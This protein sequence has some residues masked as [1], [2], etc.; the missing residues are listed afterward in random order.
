MFKT[1]TRL[2]AAGLMAATLAAPALAQ[3][4]LVPAQ[5]SIHFVSKQMGVPVEGHFG[6]FD[7]QIA[8]D[9]AK[10]ETAKIAF[11]VDTGSATLGVKET[12]AELPKPTWFNV[13]KFPQATF[14]STRVKAL[15]GGKFE[16]AGQ[17]AIKGQSQAVTVP[18]ALTQSGQL[19]TATGSFTIQRLAFKIG[20]GEWADTAMVADDVQVRFKLSL[21]GVNPL[22]AK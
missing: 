18:V 17:L 1:T 15:G 6:K 2:V 5:S 10:P 21:S 12:D 19:T 20:E 22:P 13:A 3:Q 9:P 7:A 16:V 11:T 8:F 4:K 14:Q